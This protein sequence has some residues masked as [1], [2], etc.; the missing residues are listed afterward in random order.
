MGQTCI[1]FVSLYPC[2]SCKFYRYSCYYFMFINSINIAQYTN[3]IIWLTIIFQVLGALWYFFAIE[4][5]TSCWHRACRKTAGC[6]ASAYKC[7]VSVSA[8]T[9]NITL[10]NQLCPITSPNTTEFDFGMFVKVLQSGNTGSVDFP[11]KIFYTLWWGLKNLRYKTCNFIMLSFS[12][13]T[14]LSQNVHS[15]MSIQTKTMKALKIYIPRWD[16]YDINAF[17]VLQNVIRSLTYQYIKIT[18]Q[19]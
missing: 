11:T 6:I 16:I 8:S 3:I 13:S 7:S 19:I 9:K 4:R 10:L 15:I 2:K 5:E 12:K 17:I 1:Q 14:N 18:I